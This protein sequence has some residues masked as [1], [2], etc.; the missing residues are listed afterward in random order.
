MKYRSRTPFALL[1]LIA[2]STLAAA[3]QAEDKKPAPVT[4][5]KILKVTHQIQESFPPNLVVQAVGQ[6][7]TGGYTDVKLER[8]H[9]VTPPEDGIQDYFL[10]AVPPAGPATTVISQVKAAD[11][12]KSIP[13]WVKG[14]RVSGIDKGIVV[15]MI[16]QKAEPPKPV[17]RRFTGHAEAGIGASDTVPFQQALAAAIYKMQQTLSEGGVTDATA[18]WKLVNTSGEVGG[19]D[20]RNRITVT[21]VAER[22]P[23][24]P[25][26]KKAKKGQSPKKS[27]AKE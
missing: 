2:V 4:V 21:I 25:Q 10:K 8:V 20:G 19:I 9:Y 12:W 13:E 1:S 15:I 22:Q 11:T 17:R 23:S 5:P 16:K 26:K 27:K 18:T 6:V 24:W 14:I 3:A 7:P